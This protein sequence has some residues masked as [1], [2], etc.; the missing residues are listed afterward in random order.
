MLIDFKE[1]MKHIGSKA[2]FTLIEVLIA[3]SIFI[4]F[5]GS[6]I[7]LFSQSSKINEVNK[8]RLEA[9]SLARE[10]VAEITQAVETARLNDVPWATMIASACVDFSTNTSTSKVLAYESACGN[11]WQIKNGPS[12]KVYLKEDS[13]EV[14]E[15]APPEPYIAFNREIQI[16][17]DPTYGPDIKHIQVIVSWDDYGKSFHVEENTYFTRWST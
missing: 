14:S 7:A 4:L 9:S 10:G 8:H 6:I 5:A 17:D 15:T 11:N 1:K 16:T 13:G 12:Q 2:S 3:L